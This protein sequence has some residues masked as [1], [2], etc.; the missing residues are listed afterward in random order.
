MKIFLSSLVGVL[1][2][3]LVALTGCEAGSG[4]GDTDDPAA[5]LASRLADALSGHSLAGIPLAEPGQAGALGDVLG[6]LEQY[7]VD[8]TARG[9]RRTDAGAEATLHWRWELGAGAW[10]YDT[11]VPLSEL[12]GRW[13]V[14]WGPSSLEP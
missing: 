3:S 9:T 7:P 5:R 1:S 12:D 2:A 13:V 4:A 6:S 10:A 8:V 11:S 14:E